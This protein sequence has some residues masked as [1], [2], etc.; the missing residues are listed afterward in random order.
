MLVGEIL[1]AVESSIDPHVARPVR[2]GDR[3]GL[4]DRGA[5]RAG[6]ETTD[7]E[8]GPERAQHETG[9]PEGDDARQDEVEGLHEAG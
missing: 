3:L 5:R 6:Q 2:Q 9:A 7:A 8:A 1:V 4:L